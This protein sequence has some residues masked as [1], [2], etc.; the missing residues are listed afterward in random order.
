MSVTWQQPWS[1]AGGDFVASPLDESNETSVRVWEDFDVTEAVKEHMAN[2]SSNFGFLVKHSNE[3]YGVKF[4]SSENTNQANR[5]K[6]TL[7]F[8]GDTQAPTVTTLTPDGGEVWQ[9]GKT[10]DIKWTASDNVGV[11]S[12]AIYFSKDNGSN[13]SL[14]DSTAGNT[15]SFS[16]T[17]P[18]GYDSKQCLVKIFAYDAMQNVG[19]DVSDNVFEI[20]PGTGIINQNGDAAKQVTFKR[21]KDA[22]MVYIPFNGKCLV[23][24]TN[25][26]GKVLSSFKTQIGNTWYKLPAKFS[27]GTHIVNIKTPEGTMIKKSVSL[28]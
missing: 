23:S 18:S 24:I 27:M 2:P 6:L 5:P 1:S 3:G 21:V 26:Q 17:I 13:W 15:G 14:V 16:W 20:K 25:L 12:R 8:E 7:Y 19:N 11:T 4:I 28:K 9:I 22:M 10:E